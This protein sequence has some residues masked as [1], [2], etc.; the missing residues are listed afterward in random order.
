MKTYVFVGS[1]S[2]SSSTARIQAESYAH[3]RF[4]LM[5]ETEGRWTSSVEYEEEVE[6]HP[7]FSRGLG[8]EQQDGKWIWKP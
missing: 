6:Q 1:G 5:R 7:G 3:A 4:V 8:W 2:C